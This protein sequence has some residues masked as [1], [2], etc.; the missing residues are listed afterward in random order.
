VVL[1]RV[2][3]EALTNVARHAAARHA[4]VR[5]TLENGQVRLAVEDDGRGVAGE[6]TPHLGLLGIRERVTALGGVLAIHGRPGA[7]FR[8]EATLPAGAPA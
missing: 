8:L 1:Y 3:Q 2:V 4:A 6:P 7:G 5:L